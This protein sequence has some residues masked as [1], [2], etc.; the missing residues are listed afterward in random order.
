M[1]ILSST[2][3]GPMHVISKDLNKSCVSNPREHGA[4]ILMTSQ[5]LGQTRIKRVNFS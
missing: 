4:Q 2:K 3:I 1:I 5:L